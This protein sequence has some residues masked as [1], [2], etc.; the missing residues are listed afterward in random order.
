MSGHLIDLHYYVESVLSF[1]LGFGRDQLH[2]IG[3][4]SPAP[5]GGP[6]YG[7]GDLLGA[8][9]L[10]VLLTWLLVVTV[11]VMWGTAVNLLVMMWIERKFYSRLHDRVGIKIGLPSMGFLAT[12]P[13]LGGLFKNFVKRPSHLGTGFLQNVADGVKLVQKENLTPKSADA[14]TFHVAPVLIAT[15]SLLVFAAIPFSEG[16][17]VMRQVDLA[18]N[19]TNPLGILFIL[20]AFGLAPIG[21][22]IAGWS[23]NNKYTLIGGMRSAAM[24]MSYEI[25]IILCII[26]VVILT[27]SLDPFEIVRQQTVSL[28]EAVPALSLLPPTSSAPLYIPNWFIFPQ[29]IGFIVFFVAILAEQERIPF[30]LPEAEAELVEGWLTEYSGMRFGLVF[31]FKWLRALAGS[32]L[33][34]ILYLGGWTGPAIGTGLSIGQ[35]GVFFPPQELW[36]ML[37]VYGVFLV[38][39]WISW[40]F[41]RIRIDQILHIGWKK[42][43][44]LSLVTILL[45]IAMRGL[46]VYA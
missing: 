11:M 43:I 46:G 5:L 23:S 18:G 2:G 10:L 22:L 42:L 44:P 24:L 7:L 1:L 33:L 34:V 13:L 32:S 28:G 17:A 20:A 29:I 9:W 45:A 41:P 12:I 38:W 30:D 25:P 15:S 14:F 36:F 39:V 3:T 31:G 26:A 8:E 40:T 16:F 27:G 4:A 35:V 19:S 6:L 21:I 37:K